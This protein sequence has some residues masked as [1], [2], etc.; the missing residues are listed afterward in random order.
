MSCP[1]FASRSAS[2]RVLS[3]CEIA[4]MLAQGGRRWTDTYMCVHVHVH[5]HITYIYTDIYGCNRTKRPRVG[6]TG[7]ADGRTE[8]AGRAEVKQASFSLVPAF[9]TSSRPNPASWIFAAAKPSQG[10]PTAITA[11]GLTKTSLA[12]N[13]TTSGTALPCWSSKAS[14]AGVV[15]KDCAGMVVVLG[16]NAWGAR[17]IGLT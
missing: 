13:H 5:M 14:Q 6:M 10:R 2:R 4:V 12:A 8:P 15:N 9:P 7:E 16:T 3:P 11:L 1:H 17:S